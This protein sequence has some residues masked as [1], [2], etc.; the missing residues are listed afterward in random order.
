MLGAKDAATVFE[1]VRQTAYTH[2]RVLTQEQAG[3]A[4]NKDLLQKNTTQAIQDG[5]FGLP[6]FVAT[7][8]QGKKEVFWGFDRIG[9]V[10]EFL[11]LE[12]QDRASL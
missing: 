5:A 6:F 9:L 1:K 3:S 4:E 2:G 8:A 10:Q 11:G 12:V 7:N